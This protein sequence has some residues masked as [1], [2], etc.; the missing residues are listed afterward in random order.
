MRVIAVA[1]A[2]R[3]S[4]LAVTSAEFVLAGRYRLQERIASG[5]AGVVWRAADEVLRRRVAVKLLQP[6]FA[7]EP[8][9][10]ARFRAEARN[11]SCLCHPAVAR[12]YDYGED[13]SLDVPFLVMELVDGPSMAEVLAAGRLDPGRTMNLIAQ[14]A[15]GLQAAHSAGV[16][17]RDVKPANLLIGQ[18][19]Q[20]KITDFGIASATWSE[21][22]TRSGTLVGT[23]GYLAPERFTGA[24]ATPQSDLYSLG[25]VAHECLA[26][27]PPFRGSAVDVA[28]AHLRCPLPP[29]PA[30]VPAEVAGLVAALTARDP[31]NRPS[32]ARE[33]SE[34]AARLHAADLAPSDGTWPGLV[35]AHRPA[36]ECV[37]LTD[38]TESAS[39]P[40]RP[41]IGPGLVANSRPTRRIRRPLGAV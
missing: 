16:V 23:P 1:A 26:G 12:V 14:A 3:I 19:D 39:P 11:A 15:A 13:A 4:V 6:A 38:L 24:S 34:W 27:V 32:S 20:V 22:V 8:E 37:T 5:G 33:V 29:L 28:E 40:S 10:R 7:A 31:G 9:A 36:A 41:A 35:P 2:I 18:D 30:D 17:H 21:P 25:I